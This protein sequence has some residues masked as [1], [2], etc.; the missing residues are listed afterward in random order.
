MSYELAGLPKF[1]TPPKAVRQA[2]AGALK[3]VS[4]TVNTPVGPQTVNV[5]DPA[6][7]KAALSAFTPHVSFGEPSP[8]ANAIASVPGGALTLIAG[9]G[10][11]MFLAGRMGRGRA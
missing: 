9:A 11:L 8:V 7:R 10:L 2:I 6:S 4:L 5:S 3:S 1:L